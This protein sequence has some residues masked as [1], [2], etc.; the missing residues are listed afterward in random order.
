MYEL[1]IWTTSD[2]SL[3][4]GNDRMERK[5]KSRVDCLARSFRHCSL[6][7]VHEMIFVSLPLYLLLAIHLAG[8]AT[9]S[10]YGETDSTLER[11][12]ASK[13]VAF[14]TAIIALAG[15][16]SFYT[17]ASRGAAGERR[18]AFGMLCIFIAGAMFFYRCNTWRES[19]RR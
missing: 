19:F 8:C 16:G 3:L 4:E 13:F 14:C 1:I 17:G 6:R 18:R 12:L 10:E 11:F 7:R 2:W 15:L 5:I 9:S